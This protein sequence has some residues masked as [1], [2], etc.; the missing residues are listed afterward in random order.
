MRIGDQP[1]SPPNIYGAV[2]GYPD[3]EYDYGIFSIDPENDN[4][5]YDVDW[6]DGNIETDIGPFPSGVIFPVSHT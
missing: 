4:L 2:H 6:G 1:P 5:T 3:V